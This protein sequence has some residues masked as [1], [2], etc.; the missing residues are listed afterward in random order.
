M[1]ADKRPHRGRTSRRDLEENYQPEPF[2]RKC[3]HWGAKAINFLKN[4]MSWLAVCDVRKRFGDA[5]LPRH[6]VTTASRALLRKSFREPAPAEFGELTITNQSWAHNFLIYI[7]EV[8][9]VI[10]ASAL[11]FLVSKLG[12]TAPGSFRIR[13]NIHQPDLS[14]RPIINISSRWE[15]TLSIWQC[16]QL[17]P[18]MFSKDFSIQSTDELQHALSSRKAQRNTRIVTVDANN[19]YPVSPIEDLNRDIARHVRSYYVSKSRFAVLIIK[20]T[21]IVLENQSCF[22]NPRCSSLFA[23]LQLDSVAEFIWLTL[24][25]LHATSSPS[26]V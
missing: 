25:H 26:V 24:T 13:P 6:W 11:K 3:S 10:D 18:V 5:L 4:S 20:V 17:K 8:E 21:R 7:H 23:A 2:R 22:S 14:A 12:Q 9:H 19:F 15:S 16:E 1:G